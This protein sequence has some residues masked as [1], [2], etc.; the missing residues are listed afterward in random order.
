M[1]TFIIT[2][3]YTT[4]AIKGMIDNPENREKASRSVIEAAGGSLHAFYITTGETDWLAI[5]EFADGA[6]MMPAALVTS[7]SGAVSNVKTVRAYT[8]K[9]FRAAQRKAAEIRSS[10]KAPAS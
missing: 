8:G 5:V 3:C 2:G 7:A 10:Y 1:P 6:D 9:E 4:S